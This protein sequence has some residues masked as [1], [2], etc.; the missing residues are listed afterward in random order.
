MHSGLQTNMQIKPA[1]EI[2][3]STSDLS[4]KILKLQQAAIHGTQH[5]LYL[6]LV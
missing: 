1:T 6:H 2:K 3:E 5:Q 4:K